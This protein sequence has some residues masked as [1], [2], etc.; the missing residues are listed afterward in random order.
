MSTD[1]INQHLKSVKIASLHIYDIIENI[2]K[3]F[4][5]PDDLNHRLIDTHRVH[6]PRLHHFIVACVKWY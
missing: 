2:L 4:E 3:L 1:K 6:N 5:K